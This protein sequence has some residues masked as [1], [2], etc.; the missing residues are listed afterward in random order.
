MSVMKVPVLPTPALQKSAPP[1][2]TH[3]TRTKRG[4]FQ[5]SVR[6]EGKKMKQ[7]GG[8]VRHVLSPRKKK[9]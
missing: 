7:W 2:Q 3:H 8:K 5:I 6:N 1:A 4:K 9:V